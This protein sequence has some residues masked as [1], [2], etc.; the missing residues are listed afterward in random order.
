MTT[1]TEAVEDVTYNATQPGAFKVTQDVFDNTVVS[2]TA[3]GATWYA[4]HEP[5]PEGGYTWSEPDYYADGCQ[6]HEGHLL[7]AALDD[8][9]GASC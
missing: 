3:D 9:L 8:F 6:E 4:Y 1:L 5:A 7:W 2:R